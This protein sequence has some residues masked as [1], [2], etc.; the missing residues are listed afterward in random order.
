M[1]EGFGDGLADH[2]VGQVGGSLQAEPDIVQASGDRVEKFL[3][4]VFLPGRDR[5][6]REVGEAS[7]LRALVTSRITVRVKVPVAVVTGL[8]LISAGNVVPSLRWATSR[9][10]APIGRALGAWA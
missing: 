6:L 3:A 2:V 5:G 8:R 4:A 9:A 10:P 1:L 7:S